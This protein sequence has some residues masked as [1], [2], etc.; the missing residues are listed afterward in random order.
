MFYFLLKRYVFQER[1]GSA[2]S[3]PSEM[4]GFPG[5][6]KKKKPLNLRGFGFGVALRLVFVYVVVPEA[7]HLKIFFR[8]RNLG[9]GFW[10]VVADQVFGDLPEVHFLNSP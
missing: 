4:V 9:G 1:G 2:A 8:F 3:F 6:G 10:R 5:A 7:H